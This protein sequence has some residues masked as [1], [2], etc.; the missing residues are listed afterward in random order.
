MKEVR[1]DYF[2][3]KK[4]LWRVVRGAKKISEHSTE[5][6]AREMWENLNK[7]NIKV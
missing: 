2:R 7:T 4:G 6:G 1:Y 5:K 3:V